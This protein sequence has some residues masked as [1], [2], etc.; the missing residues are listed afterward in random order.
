MAP[1]R[2]ERPGKRPN[3]SVHRS[4]AERLVETSPLPEADAYWDLGG[5]GS[6]VGDEEFTEHVPETFVEEGAS[7]ENSERD[8]GRSSRRRQGGDFVRSPVSPSSRGADS[9]HY[10]SSVVDLQRFEADAAALEVSLGIRHDTNRVLG[11]SLEVRLDRDA[12]TPGTMLFDSPTQRSPDRSTY[13]TWLD[14]ETVHTTEMVPAPPSTTQQESMTSFVSSQRREQQTTAKHIGAVHR[15]LDAAEESL[16]SRRGLPSPIDA[17]AD[18]L[19]EGA[20]LHT[21]DELG[22][23]KIFVS[24]RNSDSGRNAKMLSDQDRTSHPGS[25]TRR[26]STLPESDEASL[27]IPNQ[28]LAWDDEIPQ[29]MAHGGSEQLGRSA[30]ASPLERHIRCPK[31]SGPEL[32]KP[33][34]PACRQRHHRMLKSAPDGRCQWGEAC[35]LCSRRR[36]QRSRH[37]RTLPVWDTL[38]LHTASTGHAHID[39][40]GTSAHLDAPAT[41]LAESALSD[42][43]LL[44]TKTKRV[45]RNHV[46][47]SRQTGAAENAHEQMESTPSEAGKKSPLTNANRARSSAGALLMHQHCQACCATQVCSNCRKRHSR[48]MQR[49]GVCDWG[50][51]CRL[52]AR[53]R[54]KQLDLSHSS[55]TATLPLPFETTPDTSSSAAATTSRMPS[56]T[57]DLETASASPFLTETTNHRPLR[58]ANSR[59]HGTLSPS[60]QI[61]DQ[62]S[63][64]EHTPRD[65]V[66]GTE[67]LSAGPMNRLSGAVAADPTRRYFPRTHSSSR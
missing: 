28:E 58:S 31:C 12:A 53:K 57:M 6:D 8:A 38:D 15:S 54:R 55:E 7:S 20:R 34:C 16:S 35:R 29:Y 22:A 11:Q 52:C 45:R 42:H 64:L 32:D 9:S 60:H 27:G 62:E 25:S 44:I 30:G 59:L 49:Q 50:D 66:T 1:R 26:P 14:N 4:R 46:G 5:G 61:S 47:S 51:V 65:L 24:Q 56:T 18:D 67:L 17:N 37:E 3:A 36:R 48:M 13:T 2:G 43:G 33:V 21:D 39:G 23:A 19:P 63:D 41:L 10:L 40:T